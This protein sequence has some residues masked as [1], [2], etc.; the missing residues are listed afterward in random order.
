[1]G[2]AAKHSAN[3]TQ[4]KMPD[5]AEEK[6]MAQ[7]SQDSCARSDA[8]P[9]SIASSRRRKVRWTQTEPAAGTYSD[10]ANDFLS[11]FGNGGPTRLPQ[12]GTAVEITGLS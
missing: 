5:G 7:L 6:H 12:I 1:M 4:A 9:Y 3:C 10:P 11:T 8:D 2:F